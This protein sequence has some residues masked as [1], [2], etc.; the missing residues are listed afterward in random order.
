MVGGGKIPWGI[1]RDVK[2]DLCIAILPIGVNVIFCS[3]DNG[4]IS[5]SE[6]GGGKQPLSVA[7]VGKGA[8]P[9]AATAQ[10]TLR[11]YHLPAV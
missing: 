2:N 10:A 11:L 8:G 4:M 7:Y 1:T 9:G 6:Q 5:G 3:S